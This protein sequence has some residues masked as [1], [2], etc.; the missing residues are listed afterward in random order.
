MPLVT[1]NRSAMHYN[2]PLSSRVRLP[3]PAS[4]SPL[5]A[6]SS[7]EAS[8]NGADNPLNKPPA[9]EVKKR[10]RGATRLSCAE[11][12]R[13]RAI[14]GPHIQFTLPLVPGSNFAATVPF[15]AGRVSNAGARR[16]VQTV[17]PTSPAASCL[18]LTPSPQRILDYWQ[19]QSVS[20]PPRTSR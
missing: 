9:G 16:Y 6:M 13:Y 5:P 3:L 14:K 1:K 12:R 8:F 11:C 2:N 10:K 19:G 4:I 20:Y 15:H 18:P 17:R 7:P